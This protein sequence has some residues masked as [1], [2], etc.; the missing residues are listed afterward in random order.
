MEMVGLDREINAAMEL[1]QDGNGQG[2][3]S[4]SDVR[5]TTLLSTLEEHQGAVWVLTKPWKQLP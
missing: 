2:Q 1:F 4:L 5:P 3:G